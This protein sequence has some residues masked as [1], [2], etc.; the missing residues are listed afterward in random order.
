M[1]FEIAKVWEL[2]QENIL[3]GAF[4]V[5]VL[6]LLNWLVGRSKR[7][8]Q[9]REEQELRHHMELS[10]GLKELSRLEEDAEKRAE[11][12]TMRARAH[13]EFLAR[14]RA[15]I[16]TARSVSGSLEKRYWLLPW[17]RGF[18]AW[19]WTVLT[20]LNFAFF[21]LILAALAVAAVDGDLEIEGAAEVVALIFI[22]LVMALPTLLF[23]WF[24]FISARVTGRAL[25]RRVK[26]QAPA[27]AA[28]PA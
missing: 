8:Q 21:V 23:R 18:F 7:D 3:Q 10:R 9:S 2:L 6:P 4:A 13:R 1:E 24:S 11:L 16:A 27:A 17:P 19:I 12:E 5:V 15:Q 20:L 22:I 28:A 26:K 25:K 14:A